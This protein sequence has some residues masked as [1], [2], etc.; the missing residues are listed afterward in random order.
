ML[1]PNNA[2]C[3]REVERMTLLLHERRHYG[4]LICWLRFGE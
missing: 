3:I 1:Y 2:Y 4:M